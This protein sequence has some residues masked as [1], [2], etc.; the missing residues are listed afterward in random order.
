MAGVNS[1]TQ[2]RSIMTDIRKGKIAPAYILVGEEGYYLDRIADAILSSFGNDENSD[3][4]KNVI[5]GADAVIDEVITSARQ[6]PI[7]AEKKLVAIREAQ[8]IQRAKSELEKLESYF[9]KPNPTTIFVVVFKGSQINANTK[10]VKTAVQS[11]AVYFNSPKIRD[12][13]FDNILS[14][15]CK[16]NKINVNADAAMLLFESI[17]T[18]LSRLFCEMEKLKVAENQNTGNFTI[19][20]EMVAKNIGLNREFNNFELNSAIIHR[21]YAKAMLIADYFDRNPKENPFVVT[22]SALFSTFA[23]LMQAHYLPDRS[24]NSIKIKLGVTNSSAMKELAAGLSNYS[25]RSCMNII[26][27]L[28][29]ADCKSKGIGSMQKD[30]ELLKE[31]IF[32]IF[33]L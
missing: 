1:S 30:T 28:R 9:K 25:A 16:E 8:A 13:Q 21:D 18:D 4:N 17:G 14:D 11:G 33:T 27:A 7:F 19:T 10:W 32:K 31:L 20:A 24:A 15:F 29:D 3:F 22:V 26:E 12:Y 2:F 6:F 23:R 5:Y